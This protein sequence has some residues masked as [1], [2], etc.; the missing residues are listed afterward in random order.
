MSAGARALA[1]ADANGGNTQ[2]RGWSEERE[3]FSASSARKNFSTP[4]RRARSPI[5]SQLMK[6]QSRKTIK[7]V[8]RLAAQNHFFPFCVVCRRKSYK[9]V[10]KLRNCG[11]Q[12]ALPL[13]PNTRRLQ[14]YDT[15]DVHIRYFFRSSPRAAGRSKCAR[16]RSKCSD[17]C[18]HR[19]RT[20]VKQIGVRMTRVACSSRSYAR[21]RKRFVASKTCEQDNSLVAKLLMFYCKKK[22]KKRTHNSRF[23]RTQRKSL[24]SQTTK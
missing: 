20:R 1:A 3:R 12:L 18:G 2:N 23:V 21:V 7:I 16:A 6:N 8:A 24:L 4:T 19:Y 11:H 9:I 17:F 5:V 14:T 10:H 22:T 15:L 13:K